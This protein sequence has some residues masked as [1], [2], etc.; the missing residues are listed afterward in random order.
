LSERKKRI[1]KQGELEKGT[2]FQDYNSPQRSC[3]VL[4]TVKHEC[5]TWRKKPVKKMLQISAGR[6]PVGW[7]Q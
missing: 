1:W 2:V 4:G 7:H 6:V 3:S 5:I